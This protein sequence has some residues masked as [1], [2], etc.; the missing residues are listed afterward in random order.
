MAH[1]LFETFRD[2]LYA[3]RGPEDPGLDP[4]TCVYFWKDGECHK[5]NVIRVVIPGSIQDDHNL[6]SVNL[7]SDFRQVTDPGGPTA[8]GITI[9]QLQ[10]TDEHKLVADCTDWTAEEF[11][12]FEQMCIEKLGLP[13]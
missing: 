3:V 9:P 11:Q 7:S 2:R 8:F 12:A 5:L 13:L 10:G 6:I 1:P 4:T